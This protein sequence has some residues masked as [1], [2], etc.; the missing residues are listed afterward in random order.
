M[1]WEKVSND[2]LEEGLAH[3]LGLV[4]AGLARVCQ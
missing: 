4:S 2:Q 3:F 1:E